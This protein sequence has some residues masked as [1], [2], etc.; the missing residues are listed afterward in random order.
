MSRYWNEPEYKHG[1]PAKTGVLLVNLGT[2]E[3]PTAQALRPYL[4]QFL[5]DPRVVELP[6]LLW[7]P[8]LN[9]II[10]NTRPAKSAKKYASIWTDAGSPLKIYTQ[11]QVTL[12]KGWLGV[13]GH[14]NLVV[15]Y[16]MRYGKPS[17]E[18]RLNALKSQNCTRIL[19]VPLYPQYAASATGSVMDEV[20]RCMQHWRNVPELRMVRSYHNHSSYIDALAKRVEEHFTQNGR[21]EKLIMSFHGVPKFHLTKGD[22]YHCECHVTA[23]LLGERL[24][25]SPS[26]WQ[27]TFQSRFGRTEWLKPYTQE[28]LEQLAKGGVDRVDVVCPGFASDCLETLEEIAMEN[29]HAFIAA[30][31]KTF[32]AIPCLNDHPQWISTLGELVESHC[33]DWLANANQDMAKL[34]EQAARAR[35]A[36]AQQ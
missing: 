19:I 10:L 29:R 31:G 20:A 17:I 27:L 30:G 3:A 25:L 36:G 2:P 22:P 15:D 33:A 9:G 26:Q 14:P 12:L 28:T 5:S 8:I 7:W 6:K 11:R 34:N 24:G 21:P 35:Q 1:T 18:D 32:H 13:K 16:A 4:K 23:R